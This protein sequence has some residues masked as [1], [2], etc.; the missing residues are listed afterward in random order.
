MFVAGVQ[1]PGE[2]SRLLRGPR[3]WS[4][5]LRRMASAALLGAVECL[6]KESTIRPVFRGSLTCTSSL[7]SL[8][9]QC[10]LQG[11]PFAHARSA[12]DCL[13]PPV[14]DLLGYLWGKVGVRDRFQR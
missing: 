3:V 5:R 9:V 14:T 13:V 7:T 4:A 8:W 11:A 2:G 10:F 12:G 6:S 1:G